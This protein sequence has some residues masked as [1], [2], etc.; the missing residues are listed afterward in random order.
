[1]N[2]PRFSPPGNLVAARNGLLLEFSTPIFKAC[3]L[4]Y[5]REEQIGF[6]YGVIG[7]LNEPNPSM[8]I[9]VGF[10]GEFM[11]VINVFS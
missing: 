1:M 2:L 6:L 11:E 3:V 7:N 10:A 8:K 4:S 9:R 5:N